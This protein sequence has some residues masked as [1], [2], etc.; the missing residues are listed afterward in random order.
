MFIIL[1]SLY[2]VKGKSYEHSLIIYWTALVHH[3]KFPLYFIIKH[4]SSLKK[5]KCQEV[6]I[7]ARSLQCGKRSDFTAFPYVCLQVRCS[8]GA[9][10][11]TTLTRSSSTSF[12]ATTATSSTTMPAPGTTGTAASSGSSSIVPISSG[13]CWRW[14]P[15][16]PSPGVSVSG[17]GKTCWPLAPP[18]RGSRCR[19]GDCPRGSEI[20]AEASLVI[21]FEICDW[22]F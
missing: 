5:R 19:K 22:M 1:V 4:L 16:S 2:F 6:A 3:K 11:W 15:S 9:A 8:S 21:H 17:S 14:S 7:L 20:Y 12:P 10:T 18:T 13:S